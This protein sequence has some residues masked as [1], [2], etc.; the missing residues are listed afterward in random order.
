[1]KSIL[2]TEISCFANYSTPS[3]PK[4]VNLLTWLTSTKHKDKVDLIRSLDNKSERGLIKST[5]PAIT[6]S[7]LFTY[8]DQ[9]HLVRH[10]GFIQID[11]DLAGENIGILNWNELKNEISK[12]P[13]IAYLGLSASGRGYWGLI[14]IPPDP[15]NHKGYFDSLKEIFL[16]TWGIELDDKPKNIASLRGYSYDLEGHFNHVADLFTILKKPVTVL[17]STPKINIRPV[18]DGNYQWMESWI[19]SKI[20][21]AIPG[22]RHNTRLKYSRLAGGL[23]AGGYLPASVEESIINSYLSEFGITDPKAIQDKEIEAIRDGIKNGIKEPA[24]PPPIRCLF[25]AFTEIEDYSEKAFKIW[26]GEKWFY[27]PK[28]TVFEI[29]EFGFYVLEFFLTSDAKPP[30]YQSTAWKEFTHDADPIH[31]IIEKKTLIMMTTKPSLT[32]LRQKLEKLRKETKELEATLK[33]GNKT[34]REWKVCLYRLHRLLS[35]NGLNLEELRN[36]RGKIDL[37]N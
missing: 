17:K 4:T 31:Q 34:H 9:K 11:I 37:I 19:L 12:L 3:D 13:Q 30:S 35:G 6:P 1:M 15:E 14:P 33:E 29:L 22:D 27:I 26:Q 23:I 8:R 2:D 24:T 7:G 18:T 28:S 10:S 21:Q 25:V 32:A 5:L 16:K 36:H 20:S